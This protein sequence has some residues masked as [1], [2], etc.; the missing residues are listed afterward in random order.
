MFRDRL[1]GDRLFARIRSLDLEC[2]ACGKILVINEKTATTTY[3]R[4]TGRLQCPGCKTVY[5]LGAL[6]YPVTTG[7]TP[8][9]KAPDDWTPTIREAL[10]LRQS[11]AGFLAPSKIA[12]RAPRNIALRE[13]CRC[14]LAGSALVVHPLC[15]LHGAA[16]PAPRPDPQV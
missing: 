12:P 5:A 7:T 13:G 3:N 1:D 4:R 2:P 16:R 8:P 14:Q 15:P 11:L 6:V 10:A 9:G